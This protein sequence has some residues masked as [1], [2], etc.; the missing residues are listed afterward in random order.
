[1]VALANLGGADRPA[2]VVKE[3]AS[4]RRT[5]SLTAVALH[6]T[7]MARPALAAKPAPT[8]EECLGV[9]FTLNEGGK[10]SGQQKQSIRQSPSLGQCIAAS[11]G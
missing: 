6:M 3:V 9:Q 7:T 4:M 10:P 8:K 2:L 11:E 5:I 1:M